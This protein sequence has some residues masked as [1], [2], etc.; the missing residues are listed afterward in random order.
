MTTT[1]TP[2]ITTDRSDTTG[3]TQTGLYQ[4]DDTI[5]MLQTGLVHRPG[6]DVSKVLDAAFLVHELIC[7][8]VSGR[9]M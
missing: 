9:A 1:D 3:S 4:T 8:G 5:L 7:N 6:H 2:Q